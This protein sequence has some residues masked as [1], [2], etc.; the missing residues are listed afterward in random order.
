MNNLQ[1]ET[2][3]YDQHKNCQSPSSAELS[4]FHFITYVMPYLISC[5]MSCG[6]GFCSD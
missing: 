1:F 3:L 2:N 4:L 6:G 5:H